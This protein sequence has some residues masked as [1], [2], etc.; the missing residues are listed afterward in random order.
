MRNMSTVILLSCAATSAWPGAFEEGAAELRNGRAAMAYGRFIAAANRGDPDAAR[1]ALFMLRYGP[2]VWGSHWSASP[3]DHAAW[4]ALSDGP[5]GRHDPPFKPMH[6]PL[7]GL[8]CAAQPTVAYP[9][10]C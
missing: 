10:D 1:L 5:L 3:D 9:G 7:R 6:P 2:L 8:R 4:Q